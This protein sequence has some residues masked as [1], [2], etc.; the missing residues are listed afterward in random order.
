MI[1]EDEGLAV[2]NFDENDITSDDIETNISEQ[3]RKTN[4]QEVRHR[5]THYLLQGSLIHHIW[6]IHAP[7]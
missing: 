3:Q 2:Y 1:L 5:E 6:S 7:L 4:V